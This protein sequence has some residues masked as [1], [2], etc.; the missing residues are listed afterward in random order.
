MF[1]TKKNILCALT[2]MCV[3]VLGGNMSHA[4]NQNPIGD[5]NPIENRE[6]RN[7]RIRQQPNQNIYEKPYTYK[8]GYIDIVED[9]IYGPNGDNVFSD[10]CFP[11][12]PQQSYNIIN[13]KEQL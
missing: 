2:V 3:G 7:L 6:N 5:E 10:Y 8:K 12:P 9:Y 13:G 4:S 1:E 11:T